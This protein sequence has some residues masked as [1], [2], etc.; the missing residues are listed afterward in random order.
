[1]QKQ[2]LTEKLSSELVPLKA[3]FTISYGV[4][5]ELNK[6]EQVTEHSHDTVNFVSRTAK[7]NGVSAIVKKIDGVKPQPPGTITVAGGGSV[8]ETFLQPKPY[9]SGRDLF[10]LYPKKEM[11]ENELL[12]YVTSIRANKY[13]YNYGRQANKTLKDL[14]IPAVVPEWALN[15]PKPDYSKLRTPISNEE[16][17]LETKNW[18]YFSFTDVF[19]IKK[20]KR[21]TKAQIRD[22]LQN[23]NLNLIPFVAAK[24][25]NNAIRE[26]CRFEP[27]CDEPAI[28]VNYNGSVGESFFQE[29]PFYASDDI[30]ILKAKKKKDGTKLYSLTPQVAMFLTTIIRTE[31]YRFNYGR[32]WNL[33]RF[34]KDKI[35]LPAKADG[36]PDF[37]WMARF[38]DGLSFSHALNQF[39]DD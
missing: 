16:I 12:F 7:N 36:S 6:L 35:K 26:Y 19:E 9:Y 8:L 20:G 29:R 28:T 32:K 25:E 23:E 37:E 14:Q 10:V 11:N 30:I 5:L 17:D 4:N 21:Q 2:E 3:L 38:I 27:L 13:K 1:M 24:A 34:K 15:T 18:I 33:K 31:K 22:S 39:S